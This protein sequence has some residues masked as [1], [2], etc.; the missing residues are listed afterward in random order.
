MTPMEEADQIIAKAAAD[1]DVILRREVEKVMRAT[2]YSGFAASMGT[3]A[4][5]DKQ[6]APMDV[7][8]MSADAVATMKL[9]MELTGTFGSPG[10][11]A[12]RKGKSRA[13]KWID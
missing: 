11:Q 3:V 8:D 2:D 5:Y 10:I 9:G 13:L 1:C 6:G 7:E 12:Y 4:F